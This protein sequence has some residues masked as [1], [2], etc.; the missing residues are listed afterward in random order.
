MLRCA[1]HDNTTAQ[2]FL[3]PLITLR[4]MQLWALIVDSFRESLDRKIFWVLAAIT[5]LIVTAL[6]SIGFDAHG[7]SFLFGLWEVEVDHYNPVSVAGRSHIV[8]AILYSLTYAVLG[9]I[10]MILMIIATAG[11]FPRLLERGAVD[12]PL[13]K[14]LSRPRLFLYKYLSCMVFVFIQATLFVGL[15]FLTMG[16]RWGVW[17]PGYLLSIPL[18]VL[19]FSYLF[20]VSVLVAVKTRSA[21][22]AILLTLVAWFL[23]AA[24]STIL[25]TFE[26][27]PALKEHTRWHR[28]ARAAAWI[29]PKTADIPY[30]AARW[31]GAG[32]SLDMFPDELTDSSDPD[33]QDQMERARVLEER[34]LEK[35]PVLSIGS[36][37]I[38]EAVVVLLAMWSFAKRDY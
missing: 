29:P 2:H 28:A 20:C 19:L 11:M 23:F 9:W 14:P 12:L 15:V 6:L 8:G 31:A 38:F 13:S 7:I 36:S 1:Q 35:D 33:E 25:Q 34:E 32:T 3:L 18:L 10:G 22:A 16:L 24:P 21:A 5:L 37:L 4:L 30:L 27:F 17:A 26:T